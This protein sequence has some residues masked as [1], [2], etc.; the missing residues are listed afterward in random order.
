MRPGP[1][2]YLWSVL[3]PLGLKYKRLSDSG[4]LLVPPPYPLKAKEIEGEV[5]SL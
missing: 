1:E 5:E 3:V 4:D 2:P